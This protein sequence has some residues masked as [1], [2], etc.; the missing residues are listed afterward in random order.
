MKLCKIS[1]TDPTFILYGL[2]SRHF[3]EEK[4]LPA[5][6]RTGKAEIYSVSDIKPDKFYLLTFFAERR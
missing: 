5:F 4:I 2:K 3:S 6:V 1:N